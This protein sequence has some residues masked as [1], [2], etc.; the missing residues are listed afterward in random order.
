MGRRTSRAGRGE[1]KLDFAEDFNTGAELVQAICQILVAAVDTVDVAQDRGAGCGKH[2]DQDE[3][4]WAQR[5]RADD[6]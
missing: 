2:A 5:W 3:H 1:S 6:L 4:R